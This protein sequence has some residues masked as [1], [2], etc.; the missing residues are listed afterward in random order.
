M[1]TDY[2]W[3]KQ[4]EGFVRNVCF[5]EENYR[6]KSYLE[7]CRLQRDDCETNETRFAVDNKWATDGKKSRDTFFIDMIGKKTMN[8]TN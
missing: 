2:A 4:A 5:S 6:R 7:A 8:E 3:R 1:R